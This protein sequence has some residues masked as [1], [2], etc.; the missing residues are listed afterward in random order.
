MDAVEARMWSHVDKTEDCWTWTA[1]RNQCG[2]G[3]MKVEGRLVVVH[4]LSYEFAHGPIPAGMELDHTCHNR[5][6][7]RPEH[8]RQVT[9]KQNNENRKGARTG[10][11]SGERGV[12]WDKASGKWRAGVIHNG[13]NHYLGRFATIA[14]AKSVVVAKR[15]ELYTHNDLDRKAS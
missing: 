5:A 7:V 13:E 15:N 11:L 3:R 8:L 4:R 1:S 9:R 10:A 2:Y 12:F 14:E 6:C